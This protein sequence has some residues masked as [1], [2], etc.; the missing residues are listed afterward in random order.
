MVY[1]IAIVDDRAQN[2]NS[3]SEKLTFGGT[4]IL[5][6]KAINGQDFLEKLKALPTAQQP[7][8]VLMDVDMPVMNGIEA[9]R[10]A[11]VLYPEM[12]FL[13]L[14]VFDDEDKLF[15]A[16]KAGANGYL[17]KE[18]SVD[19]I[20]TAITEVIEKQGAPMSPRI[21]RKTLELLTN[22]NLIGEKG[23]KASSDV[24]SDME[25]EI[26]EGQVKGLDY[27]QIAEK[28][29][30]SPH[31]VRKHI[32]NIYEKLQITSKTQAINIAVKNRWF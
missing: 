32:S 14:T 2:L 18:E 6:F 19:T 24:L 11:S 28:L 26:L 27:K 1:K 30:I 4:V 20:L 3:F 21:A 17:L 23:T 8:V 13:M 25:M 12:K 10:T 29:F 15:E 5:V 22:S 16:I 9:I 7:D 31:T